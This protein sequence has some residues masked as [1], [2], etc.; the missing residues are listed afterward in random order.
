MGG[1][2][3]LFARATFYSSLTDKSFRGTGNK[4]THSFFGK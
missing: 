2:V 3:F 4:E 1:A